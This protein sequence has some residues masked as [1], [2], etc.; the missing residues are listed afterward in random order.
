[1]YL[2]F[3]SELDNNFDKFYMLNK[4]CG[5]AFFSFSFFFLFK[6]VIKPDWIVIVSISVRKFAS[7]NG[8]SCGY[9]KYLYN[10]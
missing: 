7:D 4:A 8:C 5:H 9:S 3:V 10:S 2:M 1:M 6:N